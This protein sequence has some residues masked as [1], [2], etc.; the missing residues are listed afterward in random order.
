MRTILTSENGNPLPAIQGF[1][2]RLLET[3]VVDLLLVPMRTPAG[4]VTPALVSDPVRLSEADP[5]APVMPTNTATLVGRLSYKEP[6][7]RLGAVLRACELRALV[8]LAKMQQ[9]STV[10]VILIAMDCRDLQR[11][12]IPGDGSKERGNGNCFSKQPPIARHS[13]R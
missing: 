7:P 11:T 3:G 5:L 4:T 12:K 6:R 2:R 13:H 8:E 10:D 9:A 1:L